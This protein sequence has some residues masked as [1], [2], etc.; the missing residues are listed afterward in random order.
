MQHGKEDEE[1]EQT[2]D[3][4][5]VVNDDIQPENDSSDNKKQLADMSKVELIEELKKAYNTNELLLMRYQVLK[6]LHMEI[7][8]IK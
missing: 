1:E 5:E 8:G 3:G 4:T 2:D 6:D 7:L